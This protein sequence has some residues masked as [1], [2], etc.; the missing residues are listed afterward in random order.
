MTPSAKTSASAAAAPSTRLDRF[1][2][3]AARW[4]SLFGLLF[5]ALLLASGLHLRYFYTPEAAKAYSD[6]QSLHTSVAWGLVVRNLHRWSAH[7]LLAM[8]GGLVLAVLP[9]SVRPPSARWVKVCL[10]GAVLFIALPWLIF[11]LL[12]DR[13]IRLVGFDPVL[14]KPQVRGLVRW[15]SVHPF[16][17]VGP[18]VAFVG[19]I[20][21]VQASRS[22]RNRRKGDT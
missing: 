11:L 8:L 15:Y 16:Q 13:V 9:L 5:C 17:M 7:A 21:F 6:I 1:A 14:V 3:R 19:G 4:F 18:V 10:A 20:L 22:A 2:G 12:G